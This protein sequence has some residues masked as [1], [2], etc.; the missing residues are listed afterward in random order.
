VATKLKRR[1]KPK[2]Q[3][4]SLAELPKPASDFDAKLRQEFDRS[5]VLRTV[6]IVAI[7]L[8]L[9]WIFA[10]LFAP[11]PDYKLTAAPRAHHA[12]ELD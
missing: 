5:R 4:F 9:G 7:L 3:K 10:S 1:A 2:A 6:A 12:R 8:I 11:G